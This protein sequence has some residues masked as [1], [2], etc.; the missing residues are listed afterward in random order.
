MDA[1][2]GRNNTVRPVESGDTLGR[3]SLRLLGGFELKVFPG[4]RKVPLPGKREWALLAY[5]ALS[6]KGRQPRRKLAALLWGD[7]TDETLL[8]N[9]RTCVWRLRKSLEDTNHRLLASEEEDIVLDVE[10]RSLVGPLEAA[11]N[12]VKT[13]REYDAGSFERSSVS[14]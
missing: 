3:F 1:V 2:S 12:V 13:G 14:L 4:G 5:L 11:S 6:A 7:A 8:D 9:L 10:A